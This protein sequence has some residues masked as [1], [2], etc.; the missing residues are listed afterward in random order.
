MPWL[1]PQPRGNRDLVHALRARAPLDHGGGVASTP[2]DSRMELIATL[3]QRL[4]PLS[5]GFAEPVNLAELADL[6]P[7]PERLVPAAVLV[8]LVVMPD[9]PP[10]LVFIRRTEGLPTHAGQFAFPGGRMSE[11]DQNPVATALREAREELGCDEGDFEPLGLLDTL[12]TLSAYKVQP[13]VAWTNRRLMLRP[14]PGEVAEVFRAPLDF[15]LEPA[16]LQVEE[17]EHRGRR[18]RLLSYRYEDRRIWGA[19]ALILADLARRLSSVRQW[20][21]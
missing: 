6:L 9:R 2:G 19:T 8:P 12:V 18:R 3:E 17:V 4:R 5:E 21:R 11:A 13:V 15:F 10:E 20:Q 14:E 7:P 16:H 1:R